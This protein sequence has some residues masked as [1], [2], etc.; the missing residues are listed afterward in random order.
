MGYEYE[1]PENLVG[2]HERRI[3]ERQVH[4]P[5]RRAEDPKPEKKVALPRDFVSPREQELYDL[6]DRHI[7]RL[8]EE[9]A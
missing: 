6:I 1:V 7:A 2:V 4:E 3:R 8:R 5:M 9:M